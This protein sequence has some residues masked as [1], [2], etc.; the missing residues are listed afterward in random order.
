MTDEMKTLADR[1]D[2][3]EDRADKIEA[4][5]MA[6]LDSINEKLNAMAIS[7]AGRVQCPQPGLCIHLQA[8]I[9]RQDA[10][11]DAIEKNITSLQKWQAWIMG[12]LGILLTILTLFGPALRH[13][14]G[15]SQ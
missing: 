13:A 3:I 6:A 14:L 8:A 5:F 7:M 10:R 4:K 1:V 15:F 12:G 2:R 11:I 9:V